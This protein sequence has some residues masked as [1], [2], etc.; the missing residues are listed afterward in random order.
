MQGATIQMMPATCAPTGSIGMN[1][2]F[3]NMLHGIIIGF[4][5]KKNNNA[6]Q[7]L[8]LKQEKELDAMRIFLLLVGLITL[9]SSCGQGDDVGS[10]VSGTGETPIGTWYAKGDPQIFNIKIWEFNEDGR[11]VGIASEDKGCLVVDGQW[12]IRR[13]IYGSA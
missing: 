3:I 9:S 8:Y 10:L 4:T 5:R 6:E 1:G 2:L 12:E 7:K 13:E 11:F